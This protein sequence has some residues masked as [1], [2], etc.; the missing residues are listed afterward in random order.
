[1][2]EIWEYLFISSDQLRPLPPGQYIFTCGCCEWIK[3]IYN[4]LQ[5]RRKATPRYNDQLS[6]QNANF[7]NFITS[8]FNRWFYNKDWMDF[9]RKK[10]HFE[11]NC[12]EGSQQQCWDCRESK[13]MPGCTC[14]SDKKCEKYSIGKNIGQKILYNPMEAAGLSF[15]AFW[16]CLWNF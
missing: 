6:S 12:R 10:N 4:L 14:T 7:S 2:C 11:N 5:R 13:E 1:M 16:G 15:N 3:N 9:F 8:C